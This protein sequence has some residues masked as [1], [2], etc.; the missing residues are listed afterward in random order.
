MQTLVEG[1][2]KTENFQYIS[3]IISTPPEVSNNELCLRI[4]RIFSEKQTFK[5]E[6]LE[7]CDQL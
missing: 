5:K 2:R 6:E 3:Y 4:Q 7:R 1:N